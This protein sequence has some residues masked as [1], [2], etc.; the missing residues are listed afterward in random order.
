MESCQQS[1]LKLTRSKKYYLH[2]KVFD[3]SKRKKRF[4]TDFITPTL[5]NTLFFGKSRTKAKT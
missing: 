4:F 1:N 2:L 3:S 5:L